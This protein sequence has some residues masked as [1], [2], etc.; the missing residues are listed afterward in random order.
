MKCSF[1]PNLSDIIFNNNCNNN[2]NGNAPISL[3]HQFVV[4]TDRCCGV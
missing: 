2:N 1:G 4:I 3:M